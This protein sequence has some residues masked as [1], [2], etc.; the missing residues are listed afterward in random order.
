MIF[1]IFHVPMLVANYL[2]RHCSAFREAMIVIW[3]WVTAILSNGEFSCFTLGLDASRH[4]S[5]WKLNNVE[6]LFW[7]WFNH[8]L[9]PKPN[10]Y[11]K[12]I[13]QHWGAWILGF[14]FHSLLHSHKASQ[15][16]L[17]HGVIWNLSLNLLKNEK[18]VT[19][20]EFLRRDGNILKYV[21]VILMF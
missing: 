8:F 3:P 21:K 13:L 1:W 16:D 17:F 14:Y 2:N 6:G 9:K 11:S 7:E 12:A 5:L 20:A 10:L 18:S 15:G 19:L 4:N